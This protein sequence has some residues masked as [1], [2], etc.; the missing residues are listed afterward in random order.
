MEHSEQ[1]LKLRLPNEHVEPGNEKNRFACSE[2][3]YAPGIIC[4]D[5][6]GHVTY[7]PKAHGPA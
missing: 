6:T 7:D 4:I 1:K 3:V 5:V 2:G